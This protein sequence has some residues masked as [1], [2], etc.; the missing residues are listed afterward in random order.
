MDA[1]FIR[2]VL[3]RCTLYGLLLVM[4]MFLI[5]VFAGDLVYATHANIFHI[6]RCYFDKLMYS[7]MANLKMLIF[8]FFLIPAIAITVTLKEKRD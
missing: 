8:T 5:Y 2:N 6:R 7:S 4:I 3:L 1:K